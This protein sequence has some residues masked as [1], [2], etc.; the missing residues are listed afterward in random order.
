MWKYLLIVCTLFLLVACERPL[1]E[2]EPNPTPFPAD[3]PLWPTKQPTISALTLDQLD[4]IILTREFVPPAVSKQI[5]T[6]TIQIWNQSSGRPDYLVSY[7]TNSIATIDNGQQEPIIV[8]DVWD[9]Y[10]LPLNDLTG[11]GDPEVM[12]R[13]QS[14]GS[15]CCHGILLYNLGDT[16]EMVL[17][18]S[19]GSGWIGGTWL[20]KEAPFVDLNQDGVYEIIGQEGFTDLF[21][22]QPKVKIVLAY[23][24]G[25]YVHVG[26]RY[27]DLYQDDIDRLTKAADIRLVETGELEKCDVLELVLAY[28]YAGNAEMAWSEL[29]RL[30]TAEDADAFRLKIEET[31]ANPHITENKQFPKAGIVQQ[32]DD[33]DP[34]M[35]FEQVDIYNKKRPLRIT[36]HIVLP[37]NLTKSSRS[38]TLYEKITG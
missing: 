22:T 8:Y 32:L 35:K 5:G 2:P 9:I 38:Y 6:Y 16:P 3:S 1:L 28:L 7:N 31:L 19:G 18:L 15:H 11:E 34:K 27:A 29:G 13:T 37:Y 12:I 21:C 30:Y 20:D 23:E 36:P 4:T 33:C 26:A 14:G 24:D 10:D 25:A 17:R